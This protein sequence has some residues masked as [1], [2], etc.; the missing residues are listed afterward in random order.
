MS[1]EM[2]EIL[3]VHSAC[4]SIACLGHL[5]GNMLISILAGS[6]VQPKSNV[7]LHYDNRKIF[8]IFIC[9]VLSN[10]FF[11]VPDTSSWK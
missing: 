4:F 1:Q 8:V 6:I 2:A 11:V 10:T 5:N 7:G 9:R 3:Y